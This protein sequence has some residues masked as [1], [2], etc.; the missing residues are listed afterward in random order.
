MSADKPLIDPVVLSQMIDDNTESWLGLAKSI[1]DV[2]EELRNSLIALFEP[3]NPQVGP[4]VDRV[5]AMIYKAIGRFIDDQVDDSTM[6]LLATYRQRVY[7]NAQDNH[8]TILMVEL[9]APAAIALA[10]Y[11]DTA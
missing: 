10:F 8:P 2:P 7:G 6:E 1:R 11:L 3:A 9:L 4:R 5:L